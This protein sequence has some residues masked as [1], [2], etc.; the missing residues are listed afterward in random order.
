MT[1]PTQ[2]RLDRAAEDLARLAN[3]HTE[4][5]RH[6]L[7]A[8]AGQPGA[9]TY[10]RPITTTSTL[11]APWCFTCQTDNCPH[12]K[13]MVPVRSDPTGEAATRPDP[14]AHA[15]KQYRAELAAAIKATERATQWGSLWIGRPAPTIKKREAEADKPWPACQTCHRAP[16]PDNTK[17]RWYQKS[18]TLQPTTVNRNLE[19]P[20]LLCAWC[21]KFVRKHGRPPTKAESKRHAKKQPVYVAAA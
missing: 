11:T 15:L 21:A 3:R 12:D 14:A 5:V 1:N 10:D 18:E 7:D 6:M 17:Q 13:T 16:D 4:I 2:A 8:H 20:M 9:Q 19:T